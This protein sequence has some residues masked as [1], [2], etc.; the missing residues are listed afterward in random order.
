MD[1]PDRF[2][3][4]AERCRKIANICTDPFAKKAWMKLAADWQTLAELLEAPRKLQSDGA[5]APD[6]QSK[7]RAEPVGVSPADFCGFFTQAPR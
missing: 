1:D 3:V 4:H 7:T 6:R 5:R 2:R